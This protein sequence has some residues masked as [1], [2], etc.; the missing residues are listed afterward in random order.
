[1]DYID[2]VLTGIIVLCVIIAFCAGSRPCIRNVAH[3][4]SFFVLTIFLLRRDFIVMLTTN[5]TLNTVGEILLPPLLYFVVIFCILV[6]LLLG[7]FPPVFG[8]LYF[9]KINRP[10]KELSVSLSDKSKLYPGG[11]L[12]LDVKWNGPM[13]N[14]FFEAEIVGLS[15][16]KYRIKSVH[17]DASAKEG[18]ADDGRIDYGWKWNIP[19]DFTS[20]PCKIT[21]K[22]KNTLK[23]YAFFL[24]VNLTTKKRKIKFWCGKQPHLSDAKIHA[25]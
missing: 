3:A 21:V 23:L 1:M 16:N 12:Y 9:I 18:M 8:I 24:T 17:Y 22:A 5:G 13:Y 20:G 19:D 25:K 7:A 11:V 10:P 6:V 15:N 2:Y 4:M 14:G